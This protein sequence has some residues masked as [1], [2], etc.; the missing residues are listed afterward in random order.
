MRHQLEEVIRSKDTFADPQELKIIE[1]KFQQ[2]DAV[3]G[4]MQ[5]Q[6]RDMSMGFQKK[7]EE[8]RQLAELVQDMERRMKKAQAS[9][10]SNLRFKRDIKD[11]EREAHKMRKDMIDLKS[12]ND[13]LMRQNKELKNSNTTNKPRVNSATRYNQ[14]Q[15]QPSAAIQFENKKLASDVDTFKKQNETL[16]RKIDTQKNQLAD[17]DEELAIA[18]SDKVRFK[19]LSEGYMNEIARLELQLEA[20]DVKPKSKLS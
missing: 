16:K 9:S 14:S 10:K 18:T 15:S 6:E 1:E 8:N 17:K 2:R 4:Q 11:K 19:E 5:Q 20:A 7:T 12:A 13:E 3:I